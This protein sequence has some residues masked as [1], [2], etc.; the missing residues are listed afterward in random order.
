MSQKNLAL[1]CLLWG[2]GTE[3]QGQD[4]DL[5]QIPT[6]ISDMIFMEKGVGTG[7]RAVCASVLSVL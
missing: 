3:A 6:V 7:S 1:K 5:F 4:F 2:E